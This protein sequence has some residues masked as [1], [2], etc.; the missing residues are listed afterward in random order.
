MLVQSRNTRY[1]ST[2]CMSCSS[3]HW[4]FILFTENVFLL[5]SKY[6]V[7][8]LFSAAICSEFASLTCSHS[9]CVSMLLIL[10][11]EALLFTK[12][13]WVETLEVSSYKS[14]LLEASYT[15]FLICL[16]VVSFS[17]LIY[18]TM[19]PALCRIKVMGFGMLTSWTESLLRSWDCLHKPEQGQN[20]PNS[21][22]HMRLVHEVPPLA[23]K[24]VVPFDSWKKGSQLS[25]GCSPKISPT[26]Q[27]MVLYSGVY[28]KH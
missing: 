24:R 3:F 18:L 28:R 23:K 4:C 12:E 10:W 25:L 11:P 27:Q 19:T 8:T 2:F 9:C 17:F 15:C 22:I 20:S 21:N 5:S 26:L 1:C 7:G 6:F 16:P 14:M 13:F